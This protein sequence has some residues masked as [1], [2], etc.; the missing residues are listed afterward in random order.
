MLDPTTP[1]PLMMSAFGAYVSS[2]PDEAA[3]P[4]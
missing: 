2:S 3:D 1:E 4:P